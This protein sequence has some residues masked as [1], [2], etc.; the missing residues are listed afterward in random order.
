[1]RWQGTYQDIETTWLRWATLDGEMLPTPE[2][3]EHQRAEQA[4]LQLQ[5]IVQIL[6][7]QGMNVEQITRLIG[8][9]ETQVCELMNAPQ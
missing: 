4:Q 6:F 7:Q 3:Y 8:L 5:Q 9:S 2:K 1:M